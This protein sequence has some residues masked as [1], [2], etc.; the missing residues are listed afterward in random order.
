MKKK[1]IRK[2]HPT[3]QLS[4]FIVLI[5]QALFVLFAMSLNVALVVHDK[6]NLQNS[7]DIAAYYGAMKQ[8]EMMNAIAHINYQIRQ[9]WKLLVWRYRV[10]GSMGVTRNSISNF[11]SPY[12][13]KHRFNVFSDRKPTAGPYFF[14]V[15]H[16]WWGQFE[17]GGNKTSKDILCVDI[18]QSI[19]P[20]VVPNPTGH[21]WIV[22][23]ALKGVKDLSSSINI[24]VS[25]QCDLY[26]YNSWLLGAMTFM[27]FQID[28]SNRKYMI[29]E[30]AKILEDGRELSGG[31]IEEGVKK[32]FKNNL[33]YINKTSYESPGTGSKLDTF[34]S[35]DK[36]K[37]KEWLADKPFIIK[38][39]YA[40]LYGGDDKHNP[41]G[42]S[43]TLEE[44]T[45][46][47]PR[48]ID[49][50]DKPKAEKILAIISDGSAPSW[51]DCTKF[52]RCKASD[53]IYKK[54]NFLVFYSVRAEISYKNQIFLPLMGGRDIKLKARATAMPFGGI[55]GPPP[56]TDKRLPP[57]SISYATHIP[58]TQFDEE[59]AP[60]YSRYPGD[61]LGL[62]SSLVH[63][64]WSPHLQMDPANNQ[65]AYYLNAPLGLENDPLARGDT[66]SSGAFQINARKWEL[67][68]ISPDLFDITYFT[69]LPHYTYSLFRKIQRLLNH[70]EWIRGDLGVHRIDTHNFNPEQA[71]EEQVHYSFSS[72]LFYT[73]KD[74]QH[75]LT[76]W[77]PPKRKYTV[78]NTY[79]PKSDL[80]NLNFGK[81]FL[82]VDSS[83]R[84]IETGKIPNACIYGG[85]A[86]YSVKMVSD[87][88]LKG[89]TS[90][91][92]PKPFWW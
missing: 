68:A 31:K 75:L 28:Q 80:S 13:L 69:I 36:I 48:S 85:R 90:G 59:V 91:Y 27:L 2:L 29:K 19:L 11:S 38:G 7:V 34:S 26:G 56:N 67:E 65:M 1:K 20:V 39:Y 12:D 51:P 45:S 17:S 43:K 57:P 5:F 46:K 23:D 32:T 6:I 62:R 77:N 54:N 21:F 4:I 82:W 24:K 16:K 10:L 87:D 78:D 74:M 52:D 30:L 3:G 44:I 71:I 18:D 60:N 9:S 92:H 35:L 79:E 53:G 49:P 84:E 86:G 33:S 63:H 58:F 89:K 73:I 81:C 14:C 83:R 40:D 41:S 66:A 64:Y 61:P 8:A 70:K 42:C 55:I 72:S 37:P 25:R 88:Y 76:G 15:G 47:L 50:A 22:S